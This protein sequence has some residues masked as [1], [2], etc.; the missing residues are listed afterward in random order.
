MHTA[1]WDE[2]EI[3]CR[4]VDPAFAIEHPNFTNEDKERFGHGSVKVRV[5]SRRVGF[6]IPA[7]Q[8]ELSVRRGTGGQVAHGG[9]RPERQLRLLVRRSKI[10]AD[11]A[12]L[13]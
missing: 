11:L 5:R 1:F 10:R 6:C 7:I 2:E 9:P 4:G 13:T 12:L 8:A 3:S